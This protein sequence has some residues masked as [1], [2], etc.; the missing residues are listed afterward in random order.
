MVFK[1]KNEKN[2]TP[3]GNGNDKCHERCSYFVL[4]F[5]LLMGKVRDMSR[6]CI[7]LNLFVLQNLLPV[8]QIITISKECLRR[9]T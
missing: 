6:F 5:P 2:K 4:I 9:K 1:Q 8:F 3:N 7:S